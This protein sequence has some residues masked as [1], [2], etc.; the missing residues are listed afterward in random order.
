MNLRADVDLPWL[1]SAEA[2]PMFPQ[3][4]RRVIATRP[5]A[6]SATVAP[7]DDQSESQTM[8][9]ERETNHERH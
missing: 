6:L 4:E 9:R 2:F 1:T 5:A 3:K 8:D 7:V